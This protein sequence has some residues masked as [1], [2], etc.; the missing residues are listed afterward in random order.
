MDTSDPRHTLGFMLQRLCGWGNL[1]S[2]SHLHRPQFMDPA[3][4]Q[5]TTTVTTIR[6]RHHILTPSTWPPASARKFQFTALL[7]GW[8]DKLF[9]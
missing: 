9:L 4:P 6:W 1:P 7:K 3:R 8:V 2:V 5:P